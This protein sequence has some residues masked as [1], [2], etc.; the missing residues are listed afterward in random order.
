MASSSGFQDYLQSLCTTYEQWWEE[1]AFI[2]EIKD[3]WFEFVLDGKTKS[4]KPADDQKG[5]TK[6]D[7]PADNQKVASKQPQEITK[8]VLRLIEDYQHQKIL[9]VGSPGAGKSTLLKRL[10]WNAAQKAQKDEKAPIPVFVELKDYKTTGDRAGVRGLIL[11]SLESHDPALDEETLK[12]LLARKRLLLLA[13]GLN[14]LSHEAAKAELKNLCRHQAV[15]STSRSTNDWWDIDRKLEIQPLTP[16]QVKRFLEERLPNR[17]RAEIEKLG[18]RVR[19]F[20]QT[21]LMVWMLYS[22]FRANEETPATRGEAYRSFTAL[23]VERAKAGIDLAESRFLLSKLAFEMMQS[24]KPDDPTHFSLDMT[25]VDAQNHLGSVTILNRL[26]NLHLLQASGNLGNRKIRF[27]HQSLQEYYAA[28]ALLERLQKH[29]EWLEKTPEQQWTRFQQDYLNYLKWTEAIALVFGLLGIEAQAEQLVN[30]AL[31]V[32]LYLAARLA[33]E[34]TLKVQEKA[35]NLL[36]TESTKRDLP[37]LFKVT[38]LNKS[39]SKHSIKILIKALHE[40]DAEVQE[41]ALEGLREIADTTVIQDLLWVIED[42]DGYPLIMNAIKLLAA[43]DLDKSTSSKLRELLRSQYP[44]TRELAALAL[45]KLNTEVCIPDLTLALRDPAI[46]VRRAAVSA[47]GEIGHREIVPDLLNI[48]STYGEEYNQGIFS[49]AAFALAKLDAEKAFSHPDADVRSAAVSLLDEQNT[50]IAFP[51]L[52][53]ALKDE[54]FVVRGQAIGM[55]GRLR[56]SELTE[57][58]FLAL[59]DPDSTVQMQAAYALGQLCSVEIIP[60][61]IEELK[62]KDARTRIAV[63]DTIRQLDREEAVPGLLLALEDSDESVRRS[64]SYALGQLGRRNAIPHFIE[65]LLDFNDEYHNVLIEKY[66]RKLEP[67]RKLELVEQ[68]NSQ[69]S[70]IRWD[71][72]KTLAKIASHAAIPELIKDFSEEKRVSQRL[73]LIDSLR[74]TSSEEVLPTLLN[75]LSD[76]EVAVRKH[77][78][79][80]IKHLG[81]RSHL[82]ELWRQQTQRPLEAIDSTIAA[83]QSRCGFYNYNITQFSLP[84]VA[85]SSISP[86][87][88]TSVTINIETAYSVIGNLEGNQVIHSLTQKTSEGDAKLK[89][90]NWEKAYIQ[91]QKITG[92]LLSETHEV[93]RSKAKLLRAFGFNESNV[94]VLEEELLKIACTQDVVEVLPT[95]H[96]TKYVIDGE[97]K[98]PLERTLKLRTVWIVDIGQTEPRFVT[99]RP[100]KPSNEEARYDSEN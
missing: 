83:I 78:A 13:D 11:E 36:I 62:A 93:G 29:P 50:E 22:I 77:V 63:V 55:L 9:I 59:E 88:S 7:K 90:P 60:K 86:Q 20:G 52:R 18:D 74:C 21:P 82:G 3:D 44:G 71:A 79:F 31:E 66:L 14:E 12:R 25:E 15:I 85:Q 40:G 37:L 39:H 73:R 1:N 28:E 70:H 4:D 10:L 99:A 8:P 26:L 54:S 41:K 75:A 5:K 81:N 94:S 46:R 95:A 64:A 34:I 68:L 91:R 16:E 49:T 6:S 69:D 98:T 96:G 87:S 97:I 32:D 84:V 57:E 45:G 89:L 56:I 53:T 24:Q 47:L 72:V 17:D 61:L 35:I 38:C 43:L 48:L 100:I 92:Y 23:Y 67:Q 65:I 51:K 58:V 2:E 30:L 27:C 33:G 76:E 19:D 42:S 80:A